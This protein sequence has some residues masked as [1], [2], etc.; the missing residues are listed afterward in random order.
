MQGLG[1]YG[2]LYS[3][4]CCARLNPGRVRLLTPDSAAVVLQLQLAR[5]Q[6]READL[7]KRMVNVV[8]AYNVA[9]EGHAARTA[10]VAEK[11]KMIV[12]R[13]ASWHHALALSRRSAACA[14]CTSARPLRQSLHSS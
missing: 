4:K 13:S 5:V 2:G 10:A 11:T 1:L 8:A 6:R 12:A 7:R 9:M 3:H 14:S